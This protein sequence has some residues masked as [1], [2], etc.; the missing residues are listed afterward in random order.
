[1]FS[2]GDP[3]DENDARADCDGTCAYCIEARTRPASA[4]LEP[5]EAALDEIHLQ[6]GMNA[7]GWYIKQREQDGDYE[8]LASMF[9]DIEIRELTRIRSARLLKAVDAEAKYQRPLVSG[10]GESGVL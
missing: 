4:N 3:G 6:A 10:S 9:Y 2:Q 8:P 5:L 7:L 1:M